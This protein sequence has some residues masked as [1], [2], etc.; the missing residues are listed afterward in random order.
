MIDQGKIL[1]EE[2]IGQLLLG[3]MWT[4]A[5]AESCTGGGIGNRITSISGSSAY[6]LGGIIAYHNTVKQNCLGVSP[7]ILES[8]G[9]VSH[10]TAEQ[11]AHGVR[12][13]GG[14]SVGLSVTGIAG[15]TGGTEEKPVGTVYIGVASD[16]GTEVRHFVFSGN[17]ENIRSESEDAAFTL[18]HEHLIQKSSY[19]GQ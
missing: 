13:I 4:L 12:E 9:A 19:E 1:L 2:T 3:R 18:L 6:Y 14:A 17:R 11:M 15:P 5:T 7:Q 8:F 16:M 10:K